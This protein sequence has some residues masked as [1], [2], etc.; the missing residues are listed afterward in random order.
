[1]KYVGTTLPTQEV[2]DLVERRW[3]DAG[4]VNRVQWI[5]GEESL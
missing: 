2:R 5:G 1:M 4:W 3:D